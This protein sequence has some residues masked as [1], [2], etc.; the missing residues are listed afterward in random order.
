MEL[1]HFIAQY[2]SPFF[3]SFFQAVTWLAQ[4]TVV[5]VIICWFYWCLDKQK[6]Y[7]LGLTYFLSGL[8][9]QG[10]KITF[11]IP[12]PW[13]LDPDFHAVPS[14]LAGATGYSFPSG[15]TQSGTALFS[16][17]GFAAKKKS[18]KFLFF[19]LI[20]LIGFSRMYLGVHTPWDVAVS[21]IL[22]F[23]LSAVVWYWAGPRLTKPEHTGKI[24]L[25]LFTVC[26]LLGIYTTIL[27]IPR[28]ADPEMAEDAL[29][30]CGAGLGFAIG[31]YL[32]GRCIRFSLP[33]TGKEKALRFTVGILSVIL[34]MG[35]FEFTLKRTLWG[36]VLS[37]FLLILWIVAGYPAVFC[38]REKRKKS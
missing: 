13:I 31:Y 29:K 11:R 23:L 12:R 38:Y 16:T 22:T 10:L 17:L 8:L 15:H 1:L 32:E 27:Y 21:M 35:I 3:D 20:L 9:V 5:V 33:K 30:A 6:A 36:S 34:F 26:V 24:A 28:T 2:R 4:E 37:Y 14:A 25:G 19:F 7:I 18:W